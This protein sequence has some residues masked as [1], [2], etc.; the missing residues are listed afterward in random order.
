MTRA[1]LKLLDK[2][3]DFDYGIDGN[4]SPFILACKYNLIEI[5]NKMFELND[6]VYMIE[7]EDFDKSAI[8]WICKNKIFSIGKTLFTYLDFEIVRKYESNWRKLLKSIQRENDDVSNFFA[9][10]IQ[11]HLSIIDIEKQVEIE[12]EKELSKLKCDALLKEIE[13][14]EKREEEK[15]LKKQMKKKASKEKEKA[16]KAQIQ[17]KKKSKQNTPARN[18]ATVEL[19][20]VVESVKDKIEILTDKHCADSSNSIELNIDLIQSPSSISIQTNSIQSPSLSSIDISNEFLNKK[21]EVE[22]WYFDLEEIK[23]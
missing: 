15:R 1:V 17:E 22:K 19:N 8:Y 20:K 2:G 16:R 7:N 13:E 18:K 6:K 3:C 14:E 11:K 23:F 12:K 9:H 10:H 5:V 4:E 21:F